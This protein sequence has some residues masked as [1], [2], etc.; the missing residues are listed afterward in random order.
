MFW[1]AVMK[2]G[3]VRWPIPP[4]RVLA[5]SE[6]TKK[7]RESEPGAVQNVFSLLC[8]NLSE[9]K[10]PQSLATVLLLQVRSV[11]PEHRTTH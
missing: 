1:E 4:P 6:Q 9:N 5:V 2:T 11:T 8:I 3:E 10:L 7:E